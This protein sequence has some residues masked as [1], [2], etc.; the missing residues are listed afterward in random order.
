MKHLPLHCSHT[1]KCNLKLSNFE[2]EWRII[3]VGVYAR[4]KVQKILRSEMKL[5]ARRFVHLTKYGHSK[6][7]LTGILRV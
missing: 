1:T 5:T 4:D 2:M 3:A 6:V 7:R